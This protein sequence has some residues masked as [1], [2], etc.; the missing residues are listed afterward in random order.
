MQAGQA[1]DRSNQLR[2][3]SAPETHSHRCLHRQE[4]SLQVHLYCTSTHGTCT[5][6]TNMREWIFL[7]NVPGT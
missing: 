6:P 2:V 7:Y 3:W 1:A 4:D 5:V